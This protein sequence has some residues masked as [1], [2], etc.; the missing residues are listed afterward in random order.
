MDIKIFVSLDTVFSLRGIMKPKL[1]SKFLEIPLI[2][3]SLL[4]ATKKEDKGEIS[5][6]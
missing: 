1:K 3:S 2:S 6:S 4:A 5:K